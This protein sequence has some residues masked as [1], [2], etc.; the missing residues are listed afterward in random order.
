MK[1]MLVVGTRPNF[2]KAASL[3]R[4]IQADADMQLVLVHTGQHYDHKMSDVFFQE[5]GLP[6]PDVFLGVGPGTHTETTARVMLALEPQIKA[7]RP[8]IIVVVG[9]VNSTLAASLAASQQQ[10]RLAHVEAG[11]R[12]FDRTM[13][14]ELNRIITDALSDYLFTPSPDADENL[15]REGIPPSKIFLVGNVM[16]DVLLLS[17]QRALALEI[18]RKFNLVPKN[19]T[20]LTLHRP[21]NVDSKMVLADLMSTIQEIA[22]THPVL[23]PVHP[24]T[25]ARLRDFGLLPDGH[26]GILISEPLGYL[27]FLSVMSQ[28][29]LVL[30]DSGGIQEETTV[31]GVP[32]LTLR[33]NTERP[34]TITCGTNHLVGMARENILAGFDEVMS[35][36][37]STARM[38]P[39]WDGHA[40][41][42]IIGILHNVN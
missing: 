16:I 40:A 33:E 6:E 39:L 7:H 23:F 1:L 15:H 2:I 5:L 11:L 10:V 31:L 27:E 35:H 41:K 37:G 9:D 28:A 36:N 20:L 42:R 25:H 22:R 30:T 12:S 34:I 8:D 17:Q 3:V 21:S 32:C 24:R 13:P 26:N 14:E 29:R 4:A 18:W 19:Y 38:P